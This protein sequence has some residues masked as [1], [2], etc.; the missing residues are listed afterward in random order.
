MSNRQT[1]EFCHVLASCLLLLAMM[2]CALLIA[3]EDH[4][5]VYH[6]L[7]SMV[8]ATKTLIQY[9]LAYFYKSIE[10][11]YKTGKILMFTQNQENDSHTYLKLI[12]LAK[13]SA[14]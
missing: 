10:N 3:G 6:M 7:F 1:E 14:L 13:L 8:I 5:S 11:V 4:F 2:T 12:K 9:V